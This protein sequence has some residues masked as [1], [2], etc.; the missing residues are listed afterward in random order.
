M[1]KTTATLAL[2]LLAAAVTTPAPTF[3]FSVPMLYE[4]SIARQEEGLVFAQPI[5]GL[6]NRLWFDY[7]TN[8]GEAQ[9]V[10][11]SDLRHS[12]DTE[13]LRDAWEEYRGEL[14]HERH[15][16]MKKMA[17]RGYRAGTV[18]VGG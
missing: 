17:E 12:H 3:A 16:Y 2:G 6:R 5:A 4:E 18:T 9:K 7:R 10:L 13:D 11:A 14:R 15:H 8:V 1:P